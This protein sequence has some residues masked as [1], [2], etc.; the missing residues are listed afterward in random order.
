MSGY[1]G[2]LQFSYYP[3]DNKIQ[4]DQGIY[5]HCKSIDEAN[6]FVQKVLLVYNT[7]LPNKFQGRYFKLKKLQ[8]KMVKK[9]ED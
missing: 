6:Y 4:L 5:I 8:K 9:S 1:S 2:F 3:N 7:E